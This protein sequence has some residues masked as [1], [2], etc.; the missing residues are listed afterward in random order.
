MK[1][2]KKNEIKID[3]FITLKLEEDK[4]WIYVGGKPYRPCSYILAKKSID[5][6]MDDALGS[7]NIEF[8]TEKM[9]HS[10]EGQND[11]IKLDTQLWA[12]A[13][14]LKTW[15]ENGL[16]TDLLPANFIIPLLR[17]LSEAGNMRA[18]EVFSKEIL[19]KFKSLHENTIIFLIEEEYIQFLESE[20][21]QQLFH[22]DEFLNC[23]LLIIQNCDTIIRYRVLD[24]LKNN[25][26][27][28]LLDN[29]NKII[30]SLDVNDIC[31]IFSSFYLIFDEFEITQLLKENFGGIKEI[32]IKD[33]IERIKSRLDFLDENYDWN[34]Q[35]FAINLEKFHKNYFK[36]IKHMKIMK[37]LEDF[38]NDLIGF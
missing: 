16:N 10:L 30:K 29:F 5:A 15:V 4:I 32:L 14:S 28:Y 24:A 22:N 9:D 8:L 1:I 21:I 13:S 27:S 6:I 34:K 23:L 33:F 25:N 20:E 12:Y 31:G 19:K 38:Q 3:D 26:P 36:K 11:L 35:D 37:N 7:R 18:K 2:I 17:R